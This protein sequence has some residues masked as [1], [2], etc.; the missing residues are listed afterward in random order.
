[1]L[2]ELEPVLVTTLLREAAISYH[3]YV[4]F[5]PTRPYR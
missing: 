3:N 2:N 1:M 5:P 4:D